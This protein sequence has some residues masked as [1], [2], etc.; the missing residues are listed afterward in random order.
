MRESNPSLELRRRL[1]VPTATA[2]KMWRRM[3]ALSLLALVLWLLLLPR[4]LEL[5]SRWAGQSRVIHGKMSL[6]DCYSCIGAN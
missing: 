3:L 6:I 2:L 1:T 4:A 5:V